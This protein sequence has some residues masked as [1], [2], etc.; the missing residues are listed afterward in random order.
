MQHLT[1][2]RS[3][4]FQYVIQMKA[5][6]IQV[7]KRVDSDFTPSTDY[8][9]L[10]LGLVYDYNLILFG[11]IVAAMKRITEIQEKRQKQFIRNR[12]I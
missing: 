12:Y 8:G 1:L 7:W 11:W 2:K 5:L 10:N 6:N 3:E 9:S 4:M